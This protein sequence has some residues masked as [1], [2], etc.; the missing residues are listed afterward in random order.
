LTP[1]A[2]GDM[3][4]RSPQRQAMFSNSPILDRWRNGRGGEDDDDE[5]SESPRQSN[6][7]NKFHRRSLALRSHFGKL[8]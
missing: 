6:T 8:K 7:R 2:S 3:S 5:E 4:Q 1:T